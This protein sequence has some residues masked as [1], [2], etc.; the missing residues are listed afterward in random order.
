MRISHIVQGKGDDVA[1]IT[2]DASISDALS[3]LAFRGVG[4]LVVSAD[5]V[6]PDGIISERDIVRSLHIRGASVLTCAVADVMTSLVQTCSPEDSIDAVMGVMTD[7]RIRHVP[8]VVQGELV[9]IVSIGDIVKARIDDLERTRL[10]LV[11]YIG[12]R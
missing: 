8:V 12:A 5:G 2:G 3:F 7:R 11:E 4:A 1:T 10:E 9:G 6:H